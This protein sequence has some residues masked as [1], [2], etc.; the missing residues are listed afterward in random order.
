MNKYSDVFVQDQNLG[1][2]SQV[3]ES[4]TKTNIKRLTKTFLT[5]SLVELAN[6]VGLSS[7][8]EA[9]R[10]IMDMIEEGGIHARISQKDGTYGVI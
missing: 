4:Q 1:L 5:L 9:E 8:V 10:L 2:V 3:V 7:T 6:K